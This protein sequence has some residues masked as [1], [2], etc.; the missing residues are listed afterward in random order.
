MLLPV[1]EVM[2]KSSHPVNMPEESSENP[3]P[4]RDPCGRDETHRYPILEIDRCRVCDS[5]S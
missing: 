5:K 4:H 1:R 3:M 2:L